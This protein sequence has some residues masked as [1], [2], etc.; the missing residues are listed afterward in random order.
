MTHPLARAALLGA[1]LAALTGL[2]GAPPALAQDGCAA[3]SFTVPLRF[4]LYRG[5]V[6]VASQREVLDRVAE[7]LRAC[8]GQAVELQV[9]T[10]TVRLASFNLRASRAVAEHVRALLA[11]RGV[12]PSR[13][14]A[15]GYGETLPVAND[16]RWDGRSTNERLVVR[17][18]PSAGAH[19]CPAR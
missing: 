1:A 6:D 9:H 17:A 10:D 15:C 13:I 11:E 14:A 12:E 18:I 3:L 5:Q 19:R 2:A 16:P 4:D 7:R 8:P